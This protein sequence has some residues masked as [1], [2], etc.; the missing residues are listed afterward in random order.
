MPKQKQISITPVMI[1][2]KGST[3][4]PV[5]LSAGPR[6]GSE[7][8]GSSTWHRPPYQHDIRGWKARA[9]K[10]DGGR[11]EEFLLYKSGVQRVAMKVGLVY[12][13][14]KG[15]G[16]IFS[17]ELA[18]RLHERADLRCYVAENMEGLASW[19]GLSVETFQVFSSGKPFNDLFL[20]FSRAK[21]IAN[22][23]LDF[24]PEIVLFT[25]THPLNWYII[26]QLKRR[27][28]HQP[29][30][31]GIIHDPIPHRG[32]RVW[33]RLLQLL[34]M[35]R[36][37]RRIVLSEN[38]KYYLLRKGWKNIACHPH[39]LLPLGVSSCSMELAAPPA[40]EKAL[41]LLFL[42]RFDKYKGIPYLLRAFDLLPSEVRKRVHLTLA[43]TGRLDRV[44]RR[45]IKKYNDSPS[46]SLV[47]RWLSED[48]I[49]SL[50][51]QCDLVVLPYTH[52]TQSG[53]VPIAFHYRKPVLVT[54]TGGLPEQVQFGRLGFV[55][56]AANDYAL[57]SC[58]LTVFHNRDMLKEK[59]ENVVRFMEKGEYPKWETLA[60]LILT[61]EG[62]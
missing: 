42:G 33:V 49:C 25:M 32:E 57:L 3:T 19:T 17:L 28:I 12:L 40:E 47:N 53:V 50:M 37:D 45:L 8:R 39:P 26:S 43:G 44:S 27:S 51:K 58:I 62:G 18:K 46:F 54:A 48:D 16:P 59:R 29:L 7:G 14:R 4:G 56:E 11:G 60:E 24:A 10:S 20:L 23:V 21:T 5:F 30:V 13:G 55:V 6:E 61:P 15:A 34:E 52:A 38:F 22:A 31:T 1:S 2:R 35:K 9:G 36:Y 41:K